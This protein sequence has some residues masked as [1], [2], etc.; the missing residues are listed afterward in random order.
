MATGTSPRTMTQ[1]HG[2]QH[3]GGAGVGKA[4]MYDAHSNTGHSPGSG[5]LTMPTAN[6]TGSHT[7]QGTNKVRV[8]TVNVGKDFA[9][10]QN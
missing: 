4:T 2:M 10:L 9:K 3:G 1:N 5:T 7:M 8:S 6:S